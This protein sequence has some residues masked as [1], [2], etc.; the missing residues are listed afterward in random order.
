M[1]RANSSPT[2]EVFQNISCYCLTQFHVG[3]RDSDTISK[4]LM[5]LFN[6]KQ[7]F[8][9][10]FQVQIS[11]HLM[12]LFN[13]LLVKSSSS[14]GISKHLMLLF[15]TVKN[16]SFFCLFS[17]QNISCY[18]LTYEQ[19]KVICILVK[20]QNISCYCLTRY[21]FSSFSSLFYFKTSHVIV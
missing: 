11:K 1:A 19:S 10:R 4:H 15:N 12:L 18:C 20:F 7:Q 14:K 16:L 9:E 13:I 8:K 3:R 17:F 21:H 2:L 6:K 5:L